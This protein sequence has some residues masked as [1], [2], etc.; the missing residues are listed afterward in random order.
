MGSRCAGMR[1]W[2]ARRGAEGLAA[3]GGQSESV[4][5]IFLRLAILWWARRE[6]AFSHPTKIRNLMPQ[7][8]LDHGLPDFRAAVGAFI[9]EVDLRHAPMRFDVLDEH[10]KADAART[11]DEGRLDVIVMMNIGWH[12]GS[13]LR[14]KTFTCRP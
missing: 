11:N 9:G 2:S 7:L 6:R 1:A 3:Q 10:R 13:P 8:G 12:V 4:P 14:K 5:T